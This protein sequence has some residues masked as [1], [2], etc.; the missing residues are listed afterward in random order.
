MVRVEIV[1][2]LPGVP[3]FVDAVVPTRVPVRAHAVAVV[4]RFAG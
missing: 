1:A 2:V 3:A 4:D